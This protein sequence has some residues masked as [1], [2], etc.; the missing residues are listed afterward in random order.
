MSASAPAGSVAPPRDLG[1]QQ[2][3]ID[4]AFRP[5]VTDAS[6]EVLNPATNEHLALAA[7]GREDDV[8]NGRD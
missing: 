8:A 6:F 5:S 7:D 2:H 4:G 3:Y 1:L